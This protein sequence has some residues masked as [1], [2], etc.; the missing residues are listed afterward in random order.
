MLH[1]NNYVVYTWQAEN[2]R[3]VSNIFKRLKLSEELQS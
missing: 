1:G 2:Q 3:G